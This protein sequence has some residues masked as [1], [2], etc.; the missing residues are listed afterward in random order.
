MIRAL[1]VG[2]GSL[3]LTAT[4]V[5]ATA[6]AASGYVNP[7]G[8]DSYVT[9]RI[10]MGVDFCLSAGEPIRAVGDGVVV[11]IV[12][13][14]Y[15]RQPYIWYR[16]L[17]GPYAGRYVYAAE[18]ITNLARVGQRLRAGQRLAS[19]KRSGTCIELGWGTGNGRTLA[20]STTGY[21]EGQVTVAGV[22]FARFLISLGVEGPFELTRTHRK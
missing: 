19:Y 5:K 9:G 3:A 13:N 7:L 15:R 6:V 22:S 11:G 20:Q 12:R 4:A 1:L 14:W 21:H 18:Q 10:D 2:I 16:L 17:D 8:N